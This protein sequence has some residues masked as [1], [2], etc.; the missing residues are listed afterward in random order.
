MNLKNKLLQHDFD[1][2]KMW[3]WQDQ[4]NYS[5]MEN[6]GHKIKKVKGWER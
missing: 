1:I 6:E 5:K 2:L 4:G 3:N